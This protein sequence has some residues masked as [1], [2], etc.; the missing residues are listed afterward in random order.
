VG[1]IGMKKT[2]AFLIMTACIS[3]APATNSI[4][5]STGADPE[6]PIDMEA[7]CQENYGSSASATQDDDPDSWVCGEDTPVDTA[8]ACEQQYGVGWVAKVDNPLDAHS[9]HCEFE[10]E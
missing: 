9:W 2:A 3:M 10:G 5:A 6:N 8:L 1:E 4:A 7:F